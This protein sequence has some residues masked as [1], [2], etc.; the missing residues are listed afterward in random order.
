M[1]LNYA[2]FDVVRAEQELQTEDDI[3]DLQFLDEKRQ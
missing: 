2:H 1:S 3:A